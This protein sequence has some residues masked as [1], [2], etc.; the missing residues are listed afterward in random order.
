MCLHAWR[1]YG[2]FLGSATLFGLLLLSSCDKSPTGPSKNA[3]QVTSVAPASGT[4]LG[5]TH[6]TIAGSRFAAGAAVTIGGAA[7]SDVVVVNDTTI[8]A[9]TPQHAAG[10][11]DVVVTAGGQT[12]ALRSGYSF[13][14]PQDTPNPAPVINA[15]T[16]LGTRRKEPKAFADVGET[17][18][19]TAAV[20]DDETAPDQ[21]EYSWSAS[22][23]N[24]DG[25]GR[26]VTWTAPP[27]TG[28][29]VLTLVVVEKYQ[30][31]DAQGLPVAK[32]NRTTGTVTVNVHDS[33]GEVSDMVSTFLLEFS[34]QSPSPNEIL[35]N[36]FDACPGK[37][38]EL[39]DVIANQEDGIITSY[40]LDRP[41]VDIAFDGACKF[42]A[43]GRRSSDAC[44]YVHA[45]WH[46][47]N[48]V[49]HQDLPDATGT[50]QVGAVFDGSRW[51]LCDSDWFEN[52]VDQLTPSSR[53]GSPAR[54]R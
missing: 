34:K 41:Q 25:T 27:A 40:T 20:S 36:F 3:P 26:T 33:S 19:V 15:M 53:T 49:T 31:T 39:D 13:V 6:I 28:P 37:G 11:T 16:A 23:G 12:S 35:R 22:A 8:T 30:G 7:A 14:A 51:W 32:E 21:L 1:G 18:N 10:A 44:A 43:H 29:V 17:I 52:G 4:T 38:H 50:D 46:T 24:F 47:I 2:M 5:G 54:Y 45:H 9:T 42:V 48:R